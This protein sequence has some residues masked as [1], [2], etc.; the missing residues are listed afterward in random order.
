MNKKIYII[1]PTGVGKTTFANKL[2]DKYNIKWYELDNI[3]WDDKKND[4]R[5]SNETSKLFKNILNND[6]WIIEDV[7]RPIFKEGREQ[8]NT[9]YYVKVPKIRAY[10][11]ITK[12]IINK[13]EGFKI[14]KSLIKTSNYYYKLEKVILNELEEYKD[15]LKIVNSEDINRLIGSD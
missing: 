14:W 2:S 1:G 13:K 3:Y 15:K 6:S 9:I 10:Y 7:G 5:E 8:A 12:R 11:Q 4:V